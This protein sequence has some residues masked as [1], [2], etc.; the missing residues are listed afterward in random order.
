MNIVNITDNHGNIIALDILAQAES[1]HRELRPQLP[2]DY[3]A[4]MRVI[5]AGGACMCVALDDEVVGIALW[6]LIE[7]TYEGKRL[8]VDD[9][10]THAPMRSKGVGKQLLT[11][12][13]QQARL[14]NCDVLAL[15]S[16]VQRG[17]A[18]KFYF[19]EG[20]QVSSFSFRKILE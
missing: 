3:I 6:R 10:V 16:G 18:H 2:A 9:L 1:V 15:D 13:E 19:R 12:L 11:H 7:N 17:V 4:R 5:F 14:L 20:M 8:Y